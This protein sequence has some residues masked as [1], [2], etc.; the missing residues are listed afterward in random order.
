MSGKS[1]FDIH[2]LSLET[3]RIQLLSGAPIT[4]EY[5]RKTL[6]DAKTEKSR[7][8]K[9]A[10]T[11]RREYYAAIVYNLPRIFSKMR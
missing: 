2:A 8:G 4:I 7:D 11:D 1:I 5:R 9:M 6:I 10:A 3:R